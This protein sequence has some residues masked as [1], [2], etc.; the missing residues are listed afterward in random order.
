MSYK[1]ERY[2]SIE[3]YKKII[4]L[5]KNVEEIQISE[6]SSQDLAQLW[7]KTLEIGMQGISFSDYEE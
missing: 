4:A 7:R 1:E 3:E 6:I 5:Q 2:F